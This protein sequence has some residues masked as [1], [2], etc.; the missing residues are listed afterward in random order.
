[1]DKSVKKFLDEYFVE[2]RGTNSYKWDMLKEKFGDKDLVGM[3]VADMEFKV[4]KSVQKAMIKRIEHGAFGYSFVSERDYKAFFKW[5]K[6]MHDVDLKKGWLRFSTGVVSA[7]YWAVNAFTKV[8]ESVMIVTPVYYPFKNAIHDNKRKLVTSEALLKNGKYELNFKE[9]EKKI[10]KERVKLFI[11]CSPHNPIGRVWS[12]KELDRLFGILKKHKVMIISDEI[13]QDIIIGKKKF[14]SAL[15]VK[16]GKYNDNLIVLTSASK[17]FNLASL[18]HSTLIIPDKNLRKTY[19]NFAN[20]VNKSPISLMGLIATTA[21]YEEGKEWLDGLTATVKYNYNLIKDEFK[22]AN[23]DIFVSDLEGT[24]LAWIDLTNYVK[25]DDI[26][27]FMEEKCGL[28]ID[29]G[30]WFGKN[31]KGWIRVN[32]A[33]S[34]KYIDNAL[35]NIINMIKN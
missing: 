32:L 1:M 21:G 17:T 15:N 33:T 29:Y 18:L 20:R 5:Q 26:K 28:A 24:Y 34:P 8:N 9:I 19:D 23:L 14:I 27:E 4:P 2:R 16:N 12:E 35:K 7:F 6:N 3:W 13:H 11:H 22:K 25:K 30:E 31:S 10:V